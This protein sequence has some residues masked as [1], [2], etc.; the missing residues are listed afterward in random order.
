MSPNPE[1]INENIDKFGQHPKNQN[2]FQMCEERER[3]REREK[4][5]ERERRLRQGPAKRSS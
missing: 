5:R 4:E 2:S 1:V 3:E